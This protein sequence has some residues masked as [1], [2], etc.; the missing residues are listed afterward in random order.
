MRHGVL[1]I[2]DVDELVYAEGLHPRRV[3]ARFVTEALTKDLEATTVL[4]Q[5]PTTKRVQQVAT[6]GAEHN[7]GGLEQLGP[8]LSALEAVQ[9]LCVQ[10]VVTLECVDRAHQI[11][12]RPHI[13]GLLED[14]P[15][16]HNREIQDL[17]VLVGAGCTHEIVYC[18]HNA[19]ER[20]RA[21][22]YPV[23]VRRKE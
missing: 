6:C 21:E 20:P 2:S 1:G 18:S 12:E 22:I 5:A 23:D 14:D 9:D 8:V 16:H 15:W 13:L 4:D 10:R 3:E 11:R 7:V 19:L 17:C